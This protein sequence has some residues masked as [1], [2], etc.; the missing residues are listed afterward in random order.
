MR[1]LL[2]F[3][4]ALGAIVFAVVS[5]AN[6]GSMTLMGVGRPPSGAAPF[7]VS[8]ASTDF[9]TAGA[10]TTYTFNT[11]AAGA[12]D[13]NRIVMVGISGGIANTTPSGVTIN[14]SAATHVTS[15][16]V[17]DGVDI[18]DW[19]YLAVPTGT[20]VNIVITFN[21]AETR[22]AVSVY[23]IVGPSISI[24][25]ASTGTQASGTSVS[26]TSTISS[27]GAA[28]AVT[29]IHSSSVGTVTPTNLTT[30]ANVVYGG[31]TMLAGSNVSSSGSTAMGSGG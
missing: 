5:P 18:A 28:V 12:A 30:D 21:V 26:A 9:N 7:G 29:T 2:T 14:G 17:N 10:S 31:S 1:K 3:L 19:W 20:T 16:Y 8:L 13:P 25:T 4:I 15:A 24:G 22:A 6:A 23:R 11:E 27:G